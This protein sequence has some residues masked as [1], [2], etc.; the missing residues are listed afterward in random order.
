MAETLEER[1][2]VHK[3]I[4]T[5]TAESRSIAYI[6]V[7][8]PFLMAMMMNLFIKGFLNVLF[9]PFGLLLFLAFSSLVFFAFILIKRI[10]NIR[11]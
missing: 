5:V 4:Q 10:T 11:V 2:R 6:L 7:V 9:T 1:S 8:M 3:E